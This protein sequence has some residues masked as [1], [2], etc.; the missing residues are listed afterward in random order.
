MA[1]I[2]NLKRYSRFDR[3][4]GQDL[5]MGFRCKAELAKLQPPTLIFVLFQQEEL[6]EMNS[7]LYFRPV[8]IQTAMCEIQTS[9]NASPSS[10]FNRRNWLRW[11]LVCIF[12]L[13]L[14]TLT[15]VKYKPVITLV[16]RLDSTGGI[17]WNEFLSVFLTCYY[18]HC[19]MWNTNQS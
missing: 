15:C 16:L 4:C 1:K 8:I 18:P 5:W 19:H 3:Y 6:A 10:W 7:C 13:L 14:S 2:F 9:C 17:G 12:D 11:I